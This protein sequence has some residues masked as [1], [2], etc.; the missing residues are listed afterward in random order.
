MNTA[1]LLKRQQI[2]FEERPRPNPG[3]GELLVEV[4][5]CGVCR[6]D[7]KAYRQGQRDLGM[8]RVL[9]HEFA[10]TVA[11]IGDGVTGYAL[12][13]RVQVHPGIGC[14]VCPDCLRGDDQR[15]EKMQILGFDLDGGFGRFCQIPAAG[16]GRG[17]V[18]KVPLDLPLHW[19]ALTE[20][21]ACAL[22]MLGKM[23]M[24]NGERLLIVGGGVLGCMMAKLCRRL[25]ITE[26]ILI[27]ETNP[28]KRNLA[29]KLGF[30]TASAAEAAALIKKTW[31]DGVDAAIPCCPVNFGLELSLSTPEKTAVSSAFSADSA[32]IY[33]YPTG[34]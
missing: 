32:A 26:H 30:A 9:G 1:I 2:S 24:E 13:D 28:D 21:M 29:L 6:T 10:G 20:P 3:P 33:R 12:G 5:Y 14:G 22:H 8:P 4:A 19:A 17:I 31:P 16:V 11:A 34:F 27:V 18:S 23:K 25:K 7:R 15:C